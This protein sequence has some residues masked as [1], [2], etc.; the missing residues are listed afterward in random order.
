[1]S[2]PESPDQNPA[3]TPATSTPVNT[4]ASQGPQP[5]PALKKKRNRALLKYG[6]ARLGL[7]LLLT[8]IIHGAAGLIGAPVPLV[9]SALLALIVAFPLSMLIFSGM[10]AEATETVAELTAQRKAY[11]AWVA[12]ELAER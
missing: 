11:K 2:T 10:R 1:M 6:A 5:D 3:A 8:V 9:M 4:S 12:Q 7:F